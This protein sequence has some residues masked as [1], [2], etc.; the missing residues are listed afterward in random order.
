MGV[1]LFPH[2]KVV[3]KTSSNFAGSVDENCLQEFPRL[4]ARIAEGVVRKWQNIKSLAFGPD[5][6]LDKLPEVMI[7]SNLYFFLEFCQGYIL[8]TA[9]QARLSPFYSNWLYMV[10]MSVI[11]C[12]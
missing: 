7:Q 2:D 4:D 6:C 5:H 10:F 1:V 9:L 11:L 12:D 8:K 3:L